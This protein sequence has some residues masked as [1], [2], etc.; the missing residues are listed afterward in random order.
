MKHFYSLYQHNLVRVATCNFPVRLANPFANSEQIIA[1]MRQAD[2]QKV[3]LCVFPELSLSGYSIEDLRLQHTLIDACVEAIGTICK[4]TQKLMSVLIIGAPLVFRG[5]VYNCAVVIHRGEVLGVVPKSYLPNYREFYEARQFV[6]GQHTVNET[7]VLLGKQVFFGVDLLFEASDYPDFIIGV[8]ICEDLWVPIPPSSHACMAGA[9]VI[10]NLSASNITIGKADNRLLL[11]KSQSARGICAYLYAAAGGGESSTDVAWDGELSI[12]EN[13]QI[14]AQTDRFPDGETCL[15]ADVDL[16]ILRQERMQ[17]G[18]FHQNYTSPYL[19][20]YISFSLNPPLT[21][22]GLNRPLERFPFVPSDPYRLEQDCFE[23]YMIQVSALKQRIR[24]IGAK[25]MII[26]ISGGLDSTQ[27]LLV[28]VQVADELGMNRDS[29]L[30]Y[31]MPGFGTSSKTKENAEALMEA[32]AIK[33]ECL[34]I[35]PVAEQMLKD[36]GHLYA[37]GRPVYDVTFENVQAG[38]RTDYLF[39]L[40]NQH[41]G[42]VIGTGDLSELALGWCTYGVGDQMSHYHVNAGLP[43]TLIQH[44]IRWIIHSKRVSKEVGIILQRILDTEISPELIPSQDNK[45]LQSTEAMIGPYIIIF[46]PS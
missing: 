31:T 15:I 16:D 45:T 38:L 5:A 40:A 28:A 44:L 6:S 26:G 18:T 27:A 13:G 21:D 23:A 10:A 19:Y 4:A 11:C 25:R 42:I 36:I 35:R 33:W 34:D 12:M 2:Q 46:K 3:A 1:L 39:R 14:L 20:R 32:L 7:I 17:V 9:T 37:Q 30:G 24:A 22:I 8:E 43:K 41:N 29:I